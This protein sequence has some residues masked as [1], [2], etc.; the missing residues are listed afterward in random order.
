M[1]M[2]RYPFSARILYKIA[3]MVSVGERGDNT[4][5]YVDVFDGDEADIVVVRI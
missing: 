4:P 3:P 5:C 2:E 1:D